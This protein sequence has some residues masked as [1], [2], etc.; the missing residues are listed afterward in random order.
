[1][2]RRLMVAAAIMHYPSRPDLDRPELADDVTRVTRLL[3]ET[4][5]YE[6]VPVLTTDPTWGQLHTRLREFA[7][8]CT[9]DD[10]VVVYLTGH[11][12][13][14]PAA[15]STSCC[16]ATLIATMSWGGRWR[17]RVWLTGC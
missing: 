9:P 4:F 3:C 8:C 2:F 14:S 17:P 11:G 5:G 12:S 13:T 16:P 7:L 15:A 10:Y 1:M 6:A